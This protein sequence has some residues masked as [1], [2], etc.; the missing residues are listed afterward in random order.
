MEEQ[1]KYYLSDLESGFK[2]EVSKDY[3]KSFMKAWEMF[4]PKINHT[5]GMPILF[6]TAGELDN[7]QDLKEFFYAR[8]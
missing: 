3:Y 7:N 4:I 2:Y 1:N 6:G 5:I 8:K